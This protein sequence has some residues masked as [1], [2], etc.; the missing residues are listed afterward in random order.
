MTALVGIGV[1]C[2]LLAAGFVALAMVDSEVES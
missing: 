2:F 1:L